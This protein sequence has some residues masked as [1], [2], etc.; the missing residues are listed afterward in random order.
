MPA[1]F[2]RMFFRIAPMNLGRRPIGKMDYY[3]S[4]RPTNGRYFLLWQLGA[5]SNRND[6]LIRE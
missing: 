3:L 2:Y 6:G 4:L 1:Y 5:D